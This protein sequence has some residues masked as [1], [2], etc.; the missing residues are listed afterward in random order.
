MLNHV[1][2]WIIF[3]SCAIPW[4]V[5]PS[6]SFVDIRLVCE[7]TDERGRNVRNIFLDVWETDFVCRHFWGHFVT[8]LYFT[9]FDII[10]I[11]QCLKLI[12]SHVFPR[13][14]GW[15][16]QTP[17]AGHL[18][19]DE[20]RLWF[21]EDEIKKNMLDTWKKG[22][23]GIS[24]VLKNKIPYGLCFSTVKNLQPLMVSI[25]SRCCSFDAFPPTGV[26]G[27][28]VQR[29]KLA[30]LGK[31]SF[32]HGQRVNGSPRWPHWWP[33]LG[34]DVSVSSEK[35]LEQLIWR[36]VDGRTLARV[37]MVIYMV[38]IPQFTGVFYI[39]GG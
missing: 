1:K 13:S 12:I 11:K 2:T 33:S 35:H 21:I 14:I 8:S 17:W 15:L 16:D 22:S 34:W 10:L 5:T 31:L 19:D 26:C 36:T 29:L 3:A 32:F 4:L 38:D 7:L 9:Y 6:H 30:M 37:D 39:S 28:T 27:N 20:Y 18:F 24:F 25:D 23:L